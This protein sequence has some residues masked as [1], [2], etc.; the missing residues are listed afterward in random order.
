MFACHQ[1][2]KSC[3]DHLRWEAKCATPILHTFTRKK[4]LALGAGLITKPTTIQVL[5]EVY[6]AL[7]FRLHLALALGNEPHMPKD[8]FYPTRHLGPSLPNA[9]TTKFHSFGT[10]ISHIHYSD[11]IFI[12][13]TYHN[14]KLIRRYIAWSSTFYNLHH[15]SN[16]IMNS[17]IEE[18]KDSSLVASGKWPQK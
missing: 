17:I 13:H 12:V 15:W 2:K 16:S 10:F 4:F 5:H 18:A 1:I 8:P 14:L 11:S 7:A 3:L 9:F 6:T